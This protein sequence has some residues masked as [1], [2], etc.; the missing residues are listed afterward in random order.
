MAG[1]LAPL[2]AMISHGIPELRTAPGAEAGVQQ[3]G[4]TALPTPEDRQ[5]AIPTL[6]MHKLLHS[7]EPPSEG[8]T[9]I[10]PFILEKTKPQKAGQKS[11]L[12]S[13]SPAYLTK[14]QWLQEVTCTL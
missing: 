3:G 14:Y 13:E 7:S 11:G 4:T 8:D 12:A 10:G 5:R 6:A 2:R 9:I 1:R